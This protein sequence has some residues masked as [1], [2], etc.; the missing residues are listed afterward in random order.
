MNIIISNSS[1]KPIYEQIV[2][3]VQK[4]II[5]GELRE[6]DALPSI[7]SLARELSVSVITVKK[8]YETLEERGYIMTQAGKGSIVSARSGALAREHKISVMEQHILSAIDISR[9]LMMSCDELKEM[10]GELYK[11]A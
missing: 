11:E 7:R 3:A 2:E 8:A 9:E 10:F 5:C 4:S 6:S 1:D